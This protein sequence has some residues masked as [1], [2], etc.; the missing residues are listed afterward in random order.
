MSEQKDQQHPLWTSDRAIVNSLL[1]GEPNDYNLS[2]LARLK[3]RYSGFPGAHDIKDDLEKALKRWGFTE[4]ALYAKTR[5]IHLAA[6]VYKGR[7]AKRDD[8]S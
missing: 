6:Q 2:E 5:E 1:S 4:E 3:M 8:W 7:G